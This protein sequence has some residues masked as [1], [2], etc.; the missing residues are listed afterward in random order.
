MVKLVLTLTS[1]K[2]SPCSH[3]LMR[4]NSLDL[5][6]C[7]A[8][9]VHTYYLG[10]CRHSVPANHLAEHPVFVQNAAA[11]EKG[12]K[13]G[14]VSKHPYHMRACRHS[15]L[16]NHLAEYSA[17]V[18]NTAA[19][20]KGE[21]RLPS[22]GSSGSALGRQGEHFVSSTKPHPNVCCPVKSCTCDA[23][24]RHN[25]YPADQTTASICQILFSAMVGSP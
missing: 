7:S 20:E 16:A 9:S 3:N 23:H 17:F 13:F 22:P 12:S 18:Q 21:R 10:A 19:L 1:L 6:L 14:S 24:H 4:H 5:I 11:L 15:V 25:T 8:Q 2:Y